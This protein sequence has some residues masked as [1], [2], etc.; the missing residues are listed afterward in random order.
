[1]SQTGIGNVFRVCQVEG[2]QLGQ[3]LERGEAGIG[4]PSCS[5]KAQL[6]QLFELP[7]NSEPSIGQIVRRGQMHLRQARYVFEGGEDGVGGSPP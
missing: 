5:F 2:G 1:M 7:E 3:V 6:P 4:D